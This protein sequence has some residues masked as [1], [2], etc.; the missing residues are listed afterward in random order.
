MAGL[1]NNSQLIVEVTPGYSMKG[2]QEV[3][4]KATDE[5]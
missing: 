4:R 2:A 1:D 5:K 3:E